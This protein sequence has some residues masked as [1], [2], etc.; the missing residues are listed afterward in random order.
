MKKSLLLGVVVMGIGMGVYA[1]DTMKCPMGHDMESMKDQMVES[2]V[3][4]LKKELGLSA[5]QESKV[6]ALL[7]SEMEQ[8]GVQM[9]DAQEKMK[10]L[11]ETTEDQLKEILTLE[12]QAKLSTLKKKGDACCG[13]PSKKGASCPMKKKDGHS[14]GTDE[15]LKK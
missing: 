5:D 2:R 10:A 12:Q 8:K 14:H 1:K 3:A 13:M 15:E 9:K 4:S 11:H 7:E 6:K